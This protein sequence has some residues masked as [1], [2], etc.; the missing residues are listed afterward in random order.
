MKPIF[1]KISKDTHITTKIR[2]FY[3]VLI[4][5]HYNIS[6]FSSLDSIIRFYQEPS[7]FFLNYTIFFFRIGD[8]KS[9]IKILSI[10]GGAGMNNTF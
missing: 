2:I 1:L 6:L 8:T 4:F 7:T 5:I 10:G 3:V 9:E